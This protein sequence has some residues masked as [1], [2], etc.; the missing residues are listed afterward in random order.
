MDPATATLIGAGLGVGGGIWSNMA[1]ARASEQMTHTGGQMAWAQ[2]AFQE[3]MANSAHQ[4][5]VADLKAA[6]LNPILSANS[7][8]PSPAGASSSPQMATQTN[9]F[10][11][12][13]SAAREAAFSKIQMEKNKAEVAVLRSQER[14]NSIEA[15]LTKQELPGADV[16]NT[17][18]EILRPVLHKIQ[19]S[20]KG[21]AKPESD[22][23]R[24][25][26]HIRENLLDENNK[27][28]RL[29]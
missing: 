21:S 16:R 17:G 24:K 8:A 13:A 12:M 19:E 6:G 2:M 5:E 29:P 27:L 14:K 1:N 25:A 23:D 11:G 7:G 28:R 3:R 10:E 9:V 26:R 4:R 15:E 20:M 22:L 18:Y